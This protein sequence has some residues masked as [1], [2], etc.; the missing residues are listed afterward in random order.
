MHSSQALCHFL[1]LMS[2]HSPQYCV[3][4]DEGGAF[5]GLLGYDTVQRC[6][7]PTFWGA[8][9]PTSLPSLS[10]MLVSYSVSACCHN[11]DDHDTNL[12]CCEI[13]KSHTKAMMEGKY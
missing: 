8:I 10:K 7:I 11:P 3:Q 12:H 2:K 13:L 4:K 1:P 9:L 5:C 6:R